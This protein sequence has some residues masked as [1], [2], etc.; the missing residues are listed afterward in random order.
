M[1]TVGIKSIHSSKQNPEPFLSKETNDEV[2]RMEYKNHVD[3]FFLFFLV[4]D[5][6]LIPRRPGY[7]GGGEVVP[8][9]KA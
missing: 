3:D 1:E 9:R 8:D 7:Q 4:G 2:R 6:N 5:V